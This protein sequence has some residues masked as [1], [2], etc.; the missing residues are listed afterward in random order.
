MM[1]QK[2]AKITIHSRDRLAFDQ[3]I[4]GLGKLELTDSGYFLRVPVGRSIVLTLNDLSIELTQAAVALVNGR[5]QDL[6]YI[7]QPDD[8]VVLLF[9]ILGG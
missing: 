4:T 5:T 1:V 9:Q 8:S 3:S 2:T 6:N 7:L